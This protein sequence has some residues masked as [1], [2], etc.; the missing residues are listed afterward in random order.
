MRNR[1]LSIVLLLIMILNLFAIN[2]SANTDAVISKWQKAGVIKG[3]GYGNLDLDKP[4]DRATLV[5]MINRVFGITDESMPKYNDVE[6]G[7]WYYNEVVAGVGAGYLSNE[8]NFKGYETVTWGECVA[9]V[10]KATGLSAPVNKRDMAIAAKKSDEETAFSVAV[11]EKRD[12]LKR[13]EFKSKPTKKDLIYLLDKVYDAIFSSEKAAIDFT[14][15]QRKY[16]DDDFEWDSVGGFPSGYFTTTEG[17]ASIVNENENNYVLIEKQTSD[18][19]GEI[20]KYFQP[21]SNKIT[22]ETSVMTKESAG[23]KNVIDLRTSVYRDDTSVL[24]VRLNNGY[25][26]TTDGGASTQLK[27]FETNRWYDIRLDMDLDLGEYDMYI[28]DSL[29]AAG[30]SLNKN[31]YSGH[32]GQVHYGFGSGKT[33]TIGIDNVAM[34][35]SERTEEAIYEAS[36]KPTVTVVDFQNVEPGTQPTGWSY[37]KQGSN[38]Y[39]EQSE[40]TPNRYLVFD[41]TT[42]QSSGYDRYTYTFPNPVSGNVQIEWRAKVGALSGDWKFFQ[43]ENQK[44]QV[45]FINDSIYVVDST[46]RE[47]LAYK[48]VT[49]NKWIKLKIVADTTKSTYDFYVNGQKV[50]TDVSFVASGDRISNIWMQISSSELGTMYMDDLT[51]STLGSIEPEAATGFVTEPNTET[52]KDSAWMDKYQDTP[53]ESVVEA[54]GLELN[55]FEIVDSEVASGKKAIRATKV[56]N[57]AATYVFDKESGYYS[58]DVGYIE[59]EL[60][61]N[62]LFRVYHNGKE[63]DFWYGQFDD[64]LLHVRDVKNKFYIEKGDT[65]VLE[66]YNGEDATTFDYIDF[67]EPIEPKFERGYLVQEEFH[68]PGGYARSGWDVSEEGGSARILY[69]SRNFGILDNSTTKNVWAKRVF[70]PQSGVVSSE[71]DFIYDT[72][73]DGLTMSFRSGETELVR[74]VTE[75]GTIFVENT[76]G[77]RAVYISGYEAAKQYEAKVVIDVAAKTATVVKPNAEEIKLPIPAVDSVDNFYMYSAI[78]K[79]GWLK[80]KSIDV[81]AGYIL[82]E[83]Y[84]A[85]EPGAVPKNAIVTGDAKVVTTNNDG[86]YD[87]TSLKMYDGSSVKYNYNKITGNSTIRYSFSPDENGTFTMKAGNI[88]VTSSGGKITFNSGK[89]TVELWKN[90]KL[91]QYYKLLLE[92]NSETGKI[93]VYVNN[94]KKAEVDCSN[95]HDNITFSVSGCNTILDSVVIYDDIEVSTVPEPQKVDTGDYLIGMQTCDLWHEGAHFGWDFVRPYDNRTPLAGYYDDNDQEVADWDIKWWA[96]H[97]VSVY[98][99]CWYREFRNTPIMNSHH[100]QKI[101]KIKH[102]KYSDDIKFAITYEN[103]GR[104]SSDEDFLNVIFTYWIE[105]Y[106]KHPSYLI[107]DN[108]PVIAIW[109][110]GMFLEDCG[111][112]EANA[113]LFEKAEDMLRAEGWSGAI[114]VTNYGGADETVAKRLVQSGYDYV[115]YYGAGEEIEVQTKKYENQGQLGIIDAITS[116]SQGWGA[117]AWGLSPRKTNLTLD[118]FRRGLEWAKNVYMPSYSDD[119]LAS[120]MMLFGNWNELAEGHMYIPSKLTGFGYL[121]Q[122]R[123]VFSTA[124]GEHEDIVPENNLDAL[125][126]RLWN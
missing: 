55:G 7:L 26:Y 93:A 65:F 63:I 110:H 41:K 13:N 101:E 27:S 87:T 116:F 98:F 19:T 80:L 66:G 117:E 99:P 35:S 36:I 122:M 77:N 29:V 39:V 91:N 68:A 56:G 72:P 123:D 6:S 59:N 49:A 2:V 61:K 33:G 21:M 32:I 38:V 45:V 34:Y 106:F 120:K 83:T 125:Y 25:F 30:C 81:F 67:G 119:S 69:G 31:I 64:G 86:Q 57:A 23:E 37:T 94:I 44:L 102:S 113:A 16:V 114:W 112:A 85:L 84:K 95:E 76:L 47:S 121:D 82:N 105:N 115:Y 14:Q 51:I 46:R 124:E 9:T 3:D 90:L 75:S 71:F 28:D 48:G 24:K 1:K 92:Q 50:R 118:E 103:S 111:S 89:E 11:L 17:I 88:T 53:S 73:D 4:L 74:F 18:G 12:I 100:D 79:K 5:T 52:T 40:E 78:D 104:I 8:G 22:F 70:L 58:I 20:I 62:S 42:K 10:I 60:V 126:P 54:E 96:E 108:K 43:L 15:T 109:S 107:I 97:G